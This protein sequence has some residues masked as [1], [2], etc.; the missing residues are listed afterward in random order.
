[1]L[2]HGLIVDLNGSKSMA[3]ELLPLQALALV[4]WEAMHDLIE[5]VH[6]AD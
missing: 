2:S 6:D 3:T 4:S 1:M 5:L